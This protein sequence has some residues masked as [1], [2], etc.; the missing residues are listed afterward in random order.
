VKKGMS[1]FAH[2]KKQ[3]PESRDNPQNGKKSSPAIQ[4]I[5]D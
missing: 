4:Q 5:K 1:D 2:Q 3:L